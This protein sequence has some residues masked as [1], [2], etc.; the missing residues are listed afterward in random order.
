MTW[1][2]QID[3]FKIRGVCIMGIHSLKIVRANALLMDILGCF[4]FVSVPVGQL[5]DSSWGMR[6]G[7]ECNVIRPIGWLHRCPEIQHLNQRKVGQLREIVSSQ[8]ISSHQQAVIVIL[9]TYLLS[10]VPPTM[11]LFLLKH[12]FGWALIACPKEIRKS[13]MFMERIEL[14]WHYIKTY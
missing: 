13:Q 3:C 8:F 10:V 7:Q 2:F 9:F 11:V 1:L 5:W 6:D 12:N 14:K 4:T